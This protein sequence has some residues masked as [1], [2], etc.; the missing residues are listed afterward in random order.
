MR[1]RFE[2]AFITLQVNNYNLCAGP[3]TTDS[4]AADTNANAKTITKM[5]EEE[6]ILYHLR[7]I[8][9]NDEWIVFLELKMDKNATMTAMLDEIVTTLVELDTA[10]MRENW[11]APEALLF[12]KKG[13]KASKGGKGPERDVRDVGENDRKQNNQRKCFH[14]QLV[15]HITE[16]GLSKQCGDPQKAA[17][18]EAKAPTKPSAT[19][20]LTTS[21]ENQ[22]MAASSNASSSDWIINCRCTTHLS[23]HQSMFI[24]IYKISFKYTECEWILCGH[25]ICI[26]IWKC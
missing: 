1:R 12:A 19:S 23:G 22:W 20:T 2:K 18:T 25:I 9:R 4:D 8:P 6:H 21:I 7:G 11:L 5:G 15:G 26:H 17:D 16:N 24:T 14:C 3:S 10:I 13:C